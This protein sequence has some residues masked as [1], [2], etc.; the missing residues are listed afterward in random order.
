MQG[1]ARQRWMKLYKKAARQLARE[2]AL[3]RDEKPALTAKGGHARVIQ[4]VI[5]SSTSAKQPTRD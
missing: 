2:I 4:K 5:P 3:L 1:Q